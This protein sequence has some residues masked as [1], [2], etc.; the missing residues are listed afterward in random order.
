[1]L[2]GFGAVPR[3]TA[4]V[5][6][7]PLQWPVKDPTDTLD[8]VLDISEVIAGNE[9]DAIMTLDVAISPANPGDLTL[10]SASASGFQAILWLTAGFAGTVYA[11]TVSIGTNSGRILG[12]TVLL[13][14][15]ALATP[16]VPPQAIIDQAGAAITDQA[17]Q[18]IL[19][20]E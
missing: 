13:P 17:D 3:G 10:Q 9:G 19:A 15:L 5:V 7:T 18:A 6:P 2:D 11:I 8:Y 1:V 14:V 20:S 12:R 16:A 4:Q